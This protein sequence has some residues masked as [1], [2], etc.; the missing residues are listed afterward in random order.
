MASPP[1]PGQQPGS[2]VRARAS[3]FENLI[4]WRTVTS[5]ADADAAGAASQ[6]AEASSA[7]DGD[8]KAQPSALNAGT[9][10]ERATLFEHLFS[11]VAQLRAAAAASA[12]DATPPDGSHRSARAGP[13]LGPDSGSAQDGESVASPLSIVSPGACSPTTRA[14]L[15][16][17]HNEVRLGAEM[18][19]LMQLIARQEAELAKKEEEVEQL[20]RIIRELSDARARVNTQRAELA[21]RYESLQSEFHRAVKVSELARAVSRHNL[22]KSHR[23]GNQL[24]YSQDELHRHRK[25]LAA[26][27]DKNALLAVENGELRS[28]LAALERSGYAD[29]ERHS[30]VLREYSFERQIGLY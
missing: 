3:F 30:V 1:P 6:D 20:Q 15:K 5:S 25:L 29:P 28:K 27:K 8:G 18:A 2:S 22:S 26:Y 14:A 24:R 10:L 17:S 7:H 21:A 13:R 23:A 16:I 12:G 9:V 4:R 19:K 11:T